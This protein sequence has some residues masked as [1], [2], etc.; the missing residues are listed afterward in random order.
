MLTHD[1]TLSVSAEE[2]CKVMI[3]ETA[4]TGARPERFSAQKKTEMVLRLLRGEDMD[5]LSREPRVPAAR[6]AAW[7]GTYLSGGQEA[8][9]KQPLDA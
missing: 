1:G 9:K 5:L 4:N 6:L 8:M 3:D 2:A 7:R